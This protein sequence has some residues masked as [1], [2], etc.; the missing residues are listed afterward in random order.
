MTVGVAVFST[1]NG[2]NLENAFHITRNAHLLVQLGAL[3]HVGVSLEVLDFEHI[4]TTLRGRTDQ[5]G[6]EN[7]S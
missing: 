7:P 6:S 2:S 3:R 5:L 4:A 1:E